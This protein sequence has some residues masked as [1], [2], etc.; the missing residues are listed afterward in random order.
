MRLALLV[1]PIVVAGLFAFNK[2][3][4]RESLSGPDTLQTPVYSQ[5]YDPARDPF[6][7]G[8]AALALAR[9]TGRRVLIE[10]GGEWCTWCHVIDSFLKE[11]PD[12]YAALQANF[13]VLKVNVSDENDNHEFMAGLPK[14]LGY[15]HFYITENDGSIIQSQDTAKLLEDGHYSRVRFMNFIKRWGVNG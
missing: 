4:D 15:P 11:H 3:V 5:V 14:S 13:V 9:M 12:V 10:V 7:D 1:I 6:A 8:N 2:S